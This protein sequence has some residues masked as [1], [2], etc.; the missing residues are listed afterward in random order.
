MK[1]KE[2]KLWRRW[3]LKWQGALDAAGG[4]GSCLRAGGRG[5]LCSCHSSLTAPRL[6]L[7]SGP[8]RQG[9][10]A[11]LCGAACLACCRRIQHSASTSSSCVWSRCVPRCR[12]VLGATCAAEGGHGAPPPS[13]RASFPSARQHENCRPPGPCLHAFSACPVAAGEP[14]AARRLETRREKCEPRERGAVCAVV[15]ATGLRTHAAAH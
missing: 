14:A 1:K 6:C 13:P 11:R 8:S 5:K 15:M 12:R 4:G 9:G 3:W 10:E 2:N 7:K